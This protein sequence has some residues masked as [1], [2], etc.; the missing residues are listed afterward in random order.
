[1]PTNGTARR[2]GGQRV[3]PADLSCY[4]H[5]FDFRSCACWTFDPGLSITQ[6]RP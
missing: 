1:L 2:I 6:C 5:G 3:N 4:G